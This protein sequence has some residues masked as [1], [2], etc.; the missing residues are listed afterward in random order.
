L[1]KADF[2]SKKINPSETAFVLL[3]FMYEK[4]PEGGDKYMLSVMKKGSKLSGVPFQFPFMESKK[5]DY[6]LLE[7][8][9]GDYT[10][11]KMYQG[12]NFRKISYDFTIK[13]NEV[14]YLGEYVF[15]PYKQYSKQTDYLSMGYF[16][17]KQ[18]FMKEK[19]ELSKDKKLV[20]KDIPQLKSAGFSIPRGYLVKLYNTST[21]IWREGMEY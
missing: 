5:K 17:D 4:K 11:R 15:T 2:E 12:K 8:K 14:V 18:W 19:N 3:T 16:D 6:F 1:R 20:L 9:P 10:V 13:K 7:L 21:R